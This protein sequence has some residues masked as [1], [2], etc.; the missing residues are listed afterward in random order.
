MLTRLSIQNYA[1]IDNLEIMLRPG[2][3]VITGET[4]SG[5]SI[6][7]GALQLLSGARF[8][9][10]ATPH[11]DCSTVISALF[12]G[13]DGSTR[14]LSREVLPSGRSKASIDGSQVSLTAL[15]GEAA[16]LFDIHTQG[17]NAVIASPAYQLQLIDSFAGTA[18]AIT[19]YSDI[20]R[21]YVDKRR[22][23][24]ELRTRARAAELN[25]RQ[26]RARLADLRDIAPE[27][28]E[29]SRL[30]TRYAMLS[31][32]ARTIEALT[33][34]ADTL[35][36]ADG[37]AVS[38]LRT[39]AEAIERLPLPDTSLAPRIRSAAVELKDI[40]ESLLSYLESITTDPG[41][42]E[43]IE[44]R[45]SRLYA[46]V[47]RYALSTPDELSDLLDATENAILL[48]DD[49]ETEISTLEADT[50]AIGRRL[51]E[52]A[53]ALTSMRRNAIPR[54]EQAI[55]EAARPL[56]LPNLRVAIELTPHKL[57]ATGR[58]AASLL[59][60]FNKNQAPAQLAHSAASGGEKARLMLAI[61]TI[62]PDLRPDTVQIFDEI[63]TGVS[64]H[65]ASLMGD[66]MRSSAAERQVIAVTHLPQVAA[67]GT[68]HIKV[69]KED[70]SI[71]SHTRIRE[72][73]GEDR[74][75]EI[76]TML[77][78]T[79]LTA[80]SLDNAAELLRD[81]ISYRSTSN[82]TVNANA[83]I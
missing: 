56:G 77:S 71:A 80:A 19:A 25:N 59:V 69:Y 73:E 79:E 32:S 3:T 75:H 54:V 36:E 78:G 49:D 30:E 5:K 55:L 16:R 12:T 47:K 66:M 9:H 13:S 37:A 21:Q 40:S 31:Q 44:E 7:L 11:P 1:L 4:G 52:S 67:K 18:E 76:A 64:G 65:I 51:T 6:I 68:H 81:D 57:T 27:K 22:R 53:D 58:D 43:R 35:T 82:T 48:A 70:S 17:A 62:A 33:A 20:F 60:A 10:S 14:I 2:F 61:K 29:A 28:G 38:R 46:A 74:I 41:E 72:L 26:L 8:E 24:E 23:L 83:K 15:A 42:S 50:R 34:A 39:T 63:D 45:L